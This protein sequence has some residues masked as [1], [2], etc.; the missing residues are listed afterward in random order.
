MR[1]LTN[2]EKK[3]VSFPWGTSRRY[4]SYGDFLRKTFRGRVQ[5]ISIDAGFTC[6]NRDG[7][8]GTGGCIFCDNR[9]FSPPY[10][11][12]Y[13]GITGQLREGIAFF[14]K[15]YNRTKG[16]LAYFQSFSS[17]YADLGKLQNI[18]HE[19]LAFPGVKGIIVGTRPDCID[20]KKI[21]FLSRL[22][23]KHF[24]A[25]EYGIESCYDHT[26]KRIN[27]GH[28]FSDSVKAVN[29]TSQ[30]NIHT[31]AHLI[32]G[33]PGETPEDMLKEAE[34]ISELPLNSIKFHQLQILKGTIAERQFFKNPGEFKIFTVGEYIDFIVAFLEHLNPRI[35]IERFIGEV[36]VEM[37]AVSP[38][39]NTPS[40]FINSGIEKRMEQLNTWQGKLC[41]L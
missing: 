38:W 12:P 8:K 4:N 18:C 1:E 15:R 33:L 27:R 19:A 6:P 5:K 11:N 35:A 26:L 20:M 39:S 32:F 40:E 25:I 31:T 2:T 28:T 13:K 37:L 9:A 24:I 22:R 29:M 3:D 30:A 34:I 36:P 7:T 23:E 41:K 16:Y 21:E 14:N 17:T 10:C